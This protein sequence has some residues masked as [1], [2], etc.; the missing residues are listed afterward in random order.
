[1]LD[2]A[3]L[4][5]SLSQHSRFC[6]LDWCLELGILSYS[7]YE[8]WRRGNI[9]T[10]DKCLALDKQQLS[11]LLK[12][13]E[14]HTAALLLVSEDKIYHRFGETSDRAL[15]ASRKSKLHSALTKRWLRP[16]NLIQPDLFMDNSLTI[17]ENTLCE[18]I[19]S[20]QFDLAEQKLQK[21]GDLNS[22]HMH[23]GS[24]Q[25]LLNYARHIQT[26]SET[27]LVD[28]IANKQRIESEIDA[29]E[30]EVV[31]LANELLASASRDYLAYAFRCLSE[32]IA[33]FSFC[34]Q[35]PRAHASFVL[36]KIPD[37]SALANCLMREQSLYQRPQLLHRLAVCREKQQHPNT[38]L[39]WCLLAERDISY[40]ET[41]LDAHRSGE[42]HTLWEAFGDSNE[43]RPN[44]YFAAYILTQKPSLL[45]FLDSDN[46][47]LILPETQ[48]MA[49]VLRLYVD[50]EDERDARQHLQQMS[51]TLLR[52]YMDVRAQ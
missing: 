39:I 49:R 10:L 40:T 44:H 17:V 11:A 51:P 26:L 14:Q 5:N 4:E 45:Q 8:S 33:A 24:Y 29:L 43:A 42:I 32:V 50:G 1:M 9:E 25:D 15:K 48:A 7:D 37:W 13:L 36:S 46:H 19:G 22:S 3:A 18:C 47:R 2:I 34:G 35:Y 6:L 31:P 28:S 38:L 30:Q 21:L 52:M 20:L 12:S 41:A 27:P 16:Q 23:L